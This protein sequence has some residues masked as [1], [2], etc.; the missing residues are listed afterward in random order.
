MYTMKEVD[1]KN[2]WIML[3]IL[4]EQLDKYDEME[5][6]RAEARKLVN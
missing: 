2:N 3:R 1:V 4:A 5:I 6:Q